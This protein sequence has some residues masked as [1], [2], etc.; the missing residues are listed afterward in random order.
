VVTPNTLQASLIKAALETRPYLQ[1]LVDKLASLGDGVPIMWHEEL[2]TSE[3]FI[4]VLLMFG[5][6]SN[7]RLART[8]LMEMS[9]CHSNS[10][11]LAFKYPHLYQ[12]EIGYAL[13]DHNDRRYIWSP[14]SWAFD[15][16]K[17]QIVETTGFRRLYFGVTM[18]L[19]KNEREREQFIK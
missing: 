3:S 19:N 16:R 4:E 6:V 10:E 18:E 12:R 9:H 7:G 5:R 1:K 13:T 11:R 17:N 2:V 8:R 14:H 15:R